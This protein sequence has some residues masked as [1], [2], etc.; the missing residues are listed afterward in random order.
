MPSTSV[1]IWI[2]ATP[3]QAP[4]MAAEKSDPPRPS[5]VVTVARRADEAAY[6]GHL[7]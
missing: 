3:V 5:V 2:S 6:D 4:T 7:A 1:Q